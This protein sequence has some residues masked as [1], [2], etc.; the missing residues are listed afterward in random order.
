MQY[1][2]QKLHV[3]D[4]LAC[5]ATTSTDQPSWLLLIYIV[6]NMCTLL[7]YAGAACAVLGDSFWP[8]VLSLLV[9]VSKLSCLACKYVLDLV[10]A[11]QIDT[12]G[13]LVICKI[14]VWF[15]DG[16][17]WG[18]IRKFQTIFLHVYLWELYWRTIQFLKRILNNE[19]L[20]ISF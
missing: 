2:Y 19:Q 9:S 5:D 1:S 12:D 3:C 7:T 8:I 11:L 14:I 15:E 4:V 20:M 16:K 17:M 18:K 6:T 10:W 13:K